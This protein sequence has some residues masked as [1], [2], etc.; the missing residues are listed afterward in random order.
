MAL[1]VLFDL[2]INNPRHPE[3]HSNLALLDISGGHFSRIEYASGGSLTG[4]LIAEFSYIAREYVN[5]FTSCKSSFTAVRSTMEASSQFDMTTQHGTLGTTFMGSTATESSLG[6][7]GQGTM[8]LD[9]LL[10]PIDE[11]WA[12]DDNTLLTGTDIMDLFN[13]S[14]PGI[15]PRFLNQVTEDPAWICSPAD[16]TRLL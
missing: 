12:V 10:F 15:D 16:D 1:F 8:P 14:I 13:F 6:S 4:S 2:V 7:L 9:T 5:S 3:T 11:D